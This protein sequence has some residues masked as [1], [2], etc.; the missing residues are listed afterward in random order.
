MSGDMSLL[1]SSLQI[2]NRQFWTRKSI[3]DLTDLISRF[4]YRASLYDMALFYRMF[5]DTTECSTTKLSSTNEIERPPDDKCTALSWLDLC[6][7]IRFD[8]MDPVYDADE[9]VIGANPA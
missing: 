6:L 7:Q 8:Y 2:Q 3:F 5:W 4:N 9:N 1:S